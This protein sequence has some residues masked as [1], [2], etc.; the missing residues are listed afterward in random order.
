MSPLRA[1]GDPDRVGLNDEELP[2]E[3]LDVG[4]PPAQTDEMAAQ[5]LVIATAPL[6]RSLELPELKPKAVEFDV[7]RV[8]S[9]AFCRSKSLAT[10]PQA[11]ELE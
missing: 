8:T 7:E 9:H 11:A 5:T 10:R 2:A 4:D 6:V 3:L 1:A